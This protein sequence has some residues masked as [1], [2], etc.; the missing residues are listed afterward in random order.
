MIGNNQ[1]QQLLGGGAGRKEA[2]RKEYH[3]TAT[4]KI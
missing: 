4:S 2:Y 3:K 1:K